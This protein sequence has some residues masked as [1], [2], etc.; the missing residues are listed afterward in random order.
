MEAFNTLGSALDEIYTN[1]QTS[2]ANQETAINNL[3]LDSEGT[4]A[5]EEAVDEVVS[6]INTLLNYFSNLK[7]DLTQKM[8]ESLEKYNMDKNQAGSDVESYKNE[9]L[10]SITE[11]KDNYLSNLSKNSSDT[12]EQ[13]NT[14]IESNQKNTPGFT[15]QLVNDFTTLEETRKESLTK[16]RIDM[17]TQQEQALSA[18]KSSLA[19]LETN[20]LGPFNTELMTMKNGKKKFFTDITKTTDEHH[21]NLETRMTNLSEGLKTKFDEFTE[22][23]QIVSSDG[24]AKANQ[25]LDKYIKDQQKIVSNEFKDIRNPLLNQQTNTEK[26]ITDIQSKFTSELDF[27]DQTVT[28]HYNNSKNVLEL[29]KKSVITDLSADITKLMKMKKLQKRI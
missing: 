3:V 1:I 9:S 4:E 16:I 27:L 24:N 18:Q 7:N 15:D 22:K 19:T 29:I 23:T 17:E 6:Y 2:L 5:S 10:L 21:K 20:I 26:Q 11:I 14:T 8:N 25:E 28:T 12:E 13:I